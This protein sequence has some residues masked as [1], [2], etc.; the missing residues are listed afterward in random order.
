MPK[1]D[2]SKQ[3]LIENTES[4][5]TD[6]G[7]LQETELKVSVKKLR[8]SKRLTIHVS[9]ENKVTSFSA[10]KTHK[11]VATDLTFYRSYHHKN[12][13]EFRLYSEEMLYPGQYNL[14]VTYLTRHTE[15]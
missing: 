5:T 2:L 15:V 10:I 11:G 6:L 12:L 3:F 8:P 14:V 13:E 9:P 7:S 1:R 4:T